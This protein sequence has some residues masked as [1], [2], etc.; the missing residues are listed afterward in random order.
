[1][2]DNV[3]KVFE[4]LNLEPGEHFHVSSYYE[5]NDLKEFY[6]D[7]NLRL[8]ELEFCSGKWLINTTSFRNILCGNYGI[9]K[10]M[11]FAKQDKDVLNF[12][13]MY[14]YE[15][16]YLARDEDNSLWAYTLKP[17]KVLTGWS[18]DWSDRRSVRLPEETFAFVKREDKEPFCIED[19]L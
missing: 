1:M 9:I 13:K 18:T 8:Y 17:V 6:L 16:K 15:F 10:K 3:K 7:E 5:G 19:L 2:R 14:S 12:L 4:M 11:G